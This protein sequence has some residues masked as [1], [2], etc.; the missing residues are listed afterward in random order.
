M[1]VKTKV[2]VVAFFLVALSW[3]LG[4]YVH[5]G[6]LWI[7]VLIGVNLLQSAFTGFSPFYTL[8]HALGGKKS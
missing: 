3:G 5:P 6:F 4:R 1:S 2:R 7:S 8:F